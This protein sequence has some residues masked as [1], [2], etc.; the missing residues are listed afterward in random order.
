M[1]GARSAFQILIAARI[2]GMIRAAVLLVVVSLGAASPSLAQTVTSSPRSVPAAWAGWAQCQVVTT[3][4]SYSD[5][6]THTWV[7][8]GT[9][10]MQGVFAIHPATWSVAG[11]G[12]VQRTSGSQPSKAEWTTNVTSVSAPMAIS[13]RAA[14]K[15]IVIRPWHDRLGVSAAIKG[16]EQAT[17]T[18]V[19]RAPAP[20]PLAFQA[21]ESTFPTVEGNPSGVI[22][23]SSTL[24]T[25]GTTSPMQATGS[26]RT[27]SCTWQ[28]AQAPTQI[29]RSSRTVAAHGDDAGLDG[30]DS[31]GR[32]DGDE[33]SSACAAAGDTEP[34]NSAC[35]VADSEPNPEDNQ[36]DNRLY[37]GGTNSDR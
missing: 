11:S 31:G 23:G 25:N 6:Q 35:R 28:F 5:R 18:A 26:T 4:P 32:A 37:A 24:P 29:L 2:Q 10:T 3:G 27:S 22:S 8:T 13:V 20:T 12:T 1:S 34:V 36:R 14:D 21:W 17:M 15:R 7:L 33:D 30:S 19:T 9:P 16:T